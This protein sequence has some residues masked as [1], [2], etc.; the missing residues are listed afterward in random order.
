[1][2]TGHGTPSSDPT[3]VFRDVVS[4]LRET[5]CGVHQHR[6][7]Q[8]LLTKDASGS[9]LVALVDDTERA[10]FFNPASRTLES[11][12]FD[13][14]GTHE[15]DAEVLSRSLGDPAAWVETHAARLE[16]IHPHFRWACGF[17]GRE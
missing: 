13:R 15:D 8:A 6:M 4:T 2:E 10:V 17:D 3:E 11:V 5:R 16:W 7:A 9:R 14:E 1:M 12:P